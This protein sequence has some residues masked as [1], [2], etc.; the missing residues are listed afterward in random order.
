MNIGDTQKNTGA[1]SRDDPVLATTNS[2]RVANSADVS[3]ATARLSSGPV[4][5]SI[6]RLSR[7]SADK[8]DNGTQPIYLSFGLALLLLVVFGAT[9]LFYMQSMYGSVSQLVDVHLKKTALTYTMRDVMRERMVSMNA[10]SGMKDPYARDAELIHFY[11][12]SGH[13]RVATQKLRRLP[14]SATEQSLYD[15]LMLAALVT[16]PLARRVTE[17]LV[18]EASDAD[19]RRAMT[20][21]APEQRK[22]LSLLETLVQ[23]HQ[24]AA[25]DTQQQAGQQYRQ[26]MVLLVLLGTAAMVFVALMATIATR[27]VQERNEA[28]RQQNR[29]L[30]R[31]TREKS[32]FL[33]NMSHEFRTPLNSII[34]YSEILEEDAGALGETIMRDDLQKIR[35]ASYHLLGLI[36]EVLDLSKIEAGR[37]QLAREVF[38]VSEVVEAVTATVQPLIQQNDNRLEVRLPTDIGDMCGDALKLRQILYNLLANA[39]KFTHNGRIMLEMSRS[40]SGG[41]DWVLFRV[42]DDGIGIAKDQLNS[43]FTPYNQVSGHQN[44][45]GTGLGLSISKRFCELMGG[46]ISVVSELDLG[47]AFLI[48][49]PAEL[50]PDVEQGD[51][52]LKT[53]E[54][55]SLSLVV[56]NAA[57][58]TSKRGGSLHRRRV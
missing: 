10:I 32:E 28:L 49:I 8:S 1:G 46:K 13:Y 45:G 44:Y 40:Q 47:T 55:V 56:N 41:R 35:Y 18:A 30:A 36:N 34:G 12:L 50:S 31:A 17:L 33:A 42:E 48:Q 2:T 21:V 4:Q 22:M 15:K 27:H 19:L 11:R 3:A 39:C 53:Q 24:Q 16:Q 14:M 52:E 20:V 38:A 51:P 43:L 5:A 57:E 9:A 6:R 58:Q 25:K 23:K 7:I 37:M 26:I 29:I 54:E